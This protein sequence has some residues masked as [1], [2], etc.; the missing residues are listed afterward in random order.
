MDEYNV[1]RFYR[2]AN[3]VEIYEGTKEIEKVTIAR[4]VIG[5]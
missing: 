4:E 1:E 3:T 2:D 5:K